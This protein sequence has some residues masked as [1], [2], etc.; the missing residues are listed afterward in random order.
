MDS[1]DQPDK[2]CQVFRDNKGRCLN[3]AEPF[4][5]GTSGCMNPQIRKLGGNGET[6]HRSQRRMQSQRRP[7]R[8]GGETTS[9]SPSSHHR[10]P[11]SRHHNNRRNNRGHSNPGQSRH[12]T[13]RHQNGNGEGAQNV[14]S[15]TN[16]LTVFQPQQSVPLATSS[17]THAPGMG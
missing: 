3:C 12:Y 5:N 17:G 8:V 6:Y 7:T 15:A 9:W 16:A 10:K 1:P 11:S 4:I 14:G 13:S 2:R